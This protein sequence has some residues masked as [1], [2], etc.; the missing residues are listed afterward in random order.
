MKNRR[1]TRVREYYAYALIAGIS[2]ADA[3]RMLPGF[4]MDMYKIRAE[5]DVKVNGGKIAKRQVLGG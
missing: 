2:V 1:G 5:Y 3:R 4:I